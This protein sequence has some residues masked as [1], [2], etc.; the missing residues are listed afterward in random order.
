MKK[1]TVLLLNPPGD[2]LYI[3]D[4]FCSKIS[5]GSFINQPLDFVMLSGILSNQYNIIILDAIAERLS[6]KKCFSK[7]MEMNFDALIF[8]T[9]FAS[10]EKDF[11]F[12]RKIKKSKSVRTIGIGDILFSEEAQNLALN[13]FLDAVL[14]DFTTDDI[15]KI[16]ENN[17]QGIN[18]AVFKQN[19]HIVKRESRQINKYF[20]IPMPR[21]ELFPNKRYN[22]PLARRHPF[23]SVLTSY[24]C[25]F[26]CEFCLIGQL[27]FKFRKASEIIEELKYIFSLGIREIYFGDQTFFA[28]KVE[29][30]KICEGIMEENLDLSW[31]C[32]SRVDILNEEILKIMKR[33]GCHTII[34]GVENA[35]DEILKKYNKGFTAKQ[36]KDTFRICRQIGIRTAATFI[37]G[38]PAED[39][40][41]CLE[42]IDFSKTIGCDYASFNVPVP[43][44]LTKMYEKAVANK[45]IKSEF[46]TM[47]QSGSNVIIETDRL[48]SKKIYLLRNK[49]E[50]EFYFRPFYILKRLISIRTS[51]ELKMHL[52]EA[53]DLILRIILPQ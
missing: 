34:F 23:A 44:P 37:I 46:Q 35:D 4:M 2:R 16:I 39:V 41:S 1:K 47:D 24:G 20:S 19:G 33:S 26:K 48:S 6:F 28:N 51:Y 21:H 18:N 40:R 17:L 30:L 38:L 25:P 3:R 8:L 5:K 52:K 11:E 15:A 50:R 13:D 9:G 31:S 29:S 49:A 32:Y 36:V 45:W 22:S 14:L 42:T 27:G 10:W 7:I 53:L 43:R 12:I